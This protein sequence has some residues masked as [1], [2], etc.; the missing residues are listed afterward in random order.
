[1]S[2][3]SISG[4]MSPIENEC[5]DNINERN[6]AIDARD[7]ESVQQLAGR[8]IKLCKGVFDSE[9][10]SGV[11]DNLSAASSETGN[12]TLSLTHSEKCIQTFYRNTSCHISRVLA[13]VKLKRI[14]EAR[15][16][17]DI[18]E[19][20]VRHNLANAKEYYRNEQFYDAKISHY[21]TELS[22]LE[23]LK[24]VTD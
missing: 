4:T 7:W 9:V 20:L 22:L 12:I 5:L 11:Y 21:Q 10:L 14:A 18:T 24:K 15:K 13:L 17:I 8:Y 1:M 16:Y 3:S 2:S 19:R 6:A 23:D